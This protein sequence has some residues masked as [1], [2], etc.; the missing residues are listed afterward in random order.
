MAFRRRW[1]IVLCLLCAV[2]AAARIVRWA[3]AQSFWC[4]EAFLLLN[5]QAYDLA[6]LL[7]GPLD[8]VPSTQAGPPIFIA[9]CEWLFELG[10]GERGM[11]IPSLAASVL[12]LPLFAWLAW[13]LI[14]PKGAMFATA[15]LA[16]SDKLIQQAAVV[17]PYSGD[18]LAATMLMLIATTDRWSRSMRFTLCCVAC[19]I[20]LWASLSIVFT[21]AACGLMLIPQRNDGRR[22]WIAWVVGN[23]CVAL[24]FVL[25]YW[26]VIRVQRD[27][28]LDQFWQTRSRG[29]PPGYRPDVLFM[30]WLDNT[31][32]IFSYPLRPASIL[33]CVPWL[34]AIGC[35]L[36][37][38]DWRTIALLAGPIWLVFV[39][40]LLRQYPYQGQR[41]ILFVLPSVI[42]AS[43]AGAVLCQ[44]RCR[45]LLRWS[46]VAILVLVLIGAGGVTVR[47]MFSPA[48]DSDLLRAM[49]HVESVD[50]SLPILVM[51]DDDAAIVRLYRPVTPA[52]YRLRADER[53]NPPDDFWLITSGELDRRGRFDP[54]SKLQLDR[55]G[56]EQDSTQSLVYEGGAAI[57]Y[58]RQSTGE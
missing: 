48:F 47:R 53:E 16:V 44:A 56:F 41:I 45:G 6:R 23:A 42:L 2:G 55:P 40:G 54:A 25:M 22:A 11:R 26:I 24:V 50:D 29:F 21:F 51:D 36:K 57:R 33:I 19:C 37:S 8:A 9:V 4:D 39:A 10:M 14:G 18:V 3:W 1:F 12:A 7:T 35:W 52:R 30:W 31:S 20:G 58:R 5:L 38:R 32:R 28:F 13:R 27:E 34:I 46:G 43:A 17:K 49:R 15:M